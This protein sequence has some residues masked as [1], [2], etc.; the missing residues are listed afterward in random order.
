MIKKIDSIII[1]LGGS[2][3]ISSLIGKYLL[4]NCKKNKKLFSNIKLTVINEG[5]HI[6]WLKK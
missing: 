3:S 5:I 6:N 1:I 4:N 2:G